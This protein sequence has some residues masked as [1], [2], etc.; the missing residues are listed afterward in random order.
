MCIRDSRNTVDRI[1]YNNP[2]YGFDAQSC[3]VLPVLD[4]QSPDIAMG[5]NNSF[6]YKESAV[7]EADLIGAG[8]QGMMFGYACDETDELMPAPIA[9]AHNLT[10][11]MSKDVYKRQPLTCTPPTSTRMCWLTACG[12]KP[13]RSSPRCSCLLYTSRCV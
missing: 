10:L 2:A 12:R 11:A 8:D 9:L 1:G 13:S 5:V 4:K 6:E 7:D 3:A